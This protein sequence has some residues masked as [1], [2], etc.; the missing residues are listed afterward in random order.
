MEQNVIIHLIDGV[1]KHPFPLSAIPKGKERVSASK[2]ST[3]KSSFLYT[4]ARF[5][6]T[7][8]S[9]D[10]IAAADTV[11]TAIIISVYDILMFPQQFPLLSGCC[12]KYL[13]M[14]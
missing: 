8:S 7:A 1:V 2:P 12:R 6:I 10:K 9:M 3:A 5:L 4:A 13:C 11:R 14:V